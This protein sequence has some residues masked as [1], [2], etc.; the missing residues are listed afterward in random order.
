MDVAN[1][2]KL[3]Q[4]LSIEA[5]ILII[6]PLSFY[7]VQTS[8]SE[9]STYLLYLACATISGILTILNVLMTYDLIPSFFKKQ[10]TKQIQKDNPDFQNVLMAK[11]CTKCNNLSSVKAQFCQ[12]CGAKLSKKGMLCP[13][14]FR[15][16]S[17]TSAETCEY[18]GKKLTERGINCPHCS[19]FVHVEDQEEMYCPNCGE[20]IEHISERV[21]I[22]LLRVSEFGD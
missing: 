22:K 14:C 18:C 20:K 15:F 19:E 7:L 6:V 9:S 8:V 12:Y 21:E 2:K 10:E 3:L 13:A 17:D 5:L 1:K 11:I 16:L 4:I